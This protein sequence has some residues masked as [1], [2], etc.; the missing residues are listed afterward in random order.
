MALV[1][2][3]NAK[4][5]PGTTTT[6]LVLAISWPRPVLLVE[7]D[8]AGASIL[9]G[10]FRGQLVHDR[11]LSQLAIAHSH[12]ELET[13]LWDQTLTLVQNSQD[14][15]LLPG[16]VS[17]HLAPS[18][19]NLWTALA[20]QLVALERGGMD[21]IVDLGRLGPAGRDDREPLLRL[22]DQVI[23]TTGSRLPDIAVSRELV[24][25]RTSVIEAA[26]RD[27][28]N[29]ATLTIGPGRPYD[30]KEIARTLGLG[31]LG[32]LAWDPVNAEVLSVGSPT[33]R[34]WGSSPLVRS[35]GPVISAIQERTAARRER[36][37]TSSPAR[38]TSTGNGS[39]GGIGR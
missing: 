11:G 18:V 5:S 12:G 31:S 36:F 17:P 19:A 30:T 37:S 7:A 34:K 14:K 25:S 26:A 13:A 23:V 20:N 33:G 22:A 28:T 35:A 16:I 32:S 10:Y 6:A 4:G 15:K 21:V 8:L 29:L 2:L 27:L 39:T 9:A 38:G 24:R 1:A 3:A